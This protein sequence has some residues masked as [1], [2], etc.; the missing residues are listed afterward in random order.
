[1]NWPQQQEPVDAGFR[2]WTKS[3]REGLGMQYGVIAKEFWLGKW[4]VD[5]NNSESEWDHYFDPKSDRLYIKTE[6][7]YTTHDKTKAGRREITYNATSV[8]TAETI[9]ASSN[10]VDVCIDAQT[11]IVTVFF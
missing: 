10:P 3:L 6:D 4:T 1:L 9:P 8:A 5:N 11:I 2:Q 7:G